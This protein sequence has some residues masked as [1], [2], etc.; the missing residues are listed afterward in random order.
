MTLQ[1]HISKRKNRGLVGKIVPVLLEGFS[2]ESD[3][4]L[5]GRTASMAPDVDG[6]VLITRGQGKVGEILP[7]RIT[8]AHSYDLV[9]ELV[10]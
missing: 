6:H 7:V 9:G 5:K 1:S 4:L 8:E 10:E 3:L 2:E